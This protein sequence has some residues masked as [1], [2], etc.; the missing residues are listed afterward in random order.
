MARG[1]WAVIVRWSVTAARG[2]VD[3]GDPVRRR[4]RDVGLRVARERDAHGFVE[5]RCIGGRVEVVDGGDHLLEEAALRVAVDHAHGVGDVVGH[6]DLG[7]VR[8]Y[9]D[10]DGVHADVDAVDHLETCRVD[11][12]N[13]VG[14]CVDDVDE[15]AVD[16]DRVGMRTGERRPADVLGDVDDDARIGPEAGGR[17]GAEHNGGPCA[18]APSPLFPLNRHPPDR[19]G[20]VVRR[21]PSVAGELSTRRLG[22]QGD[23]PLRLPGGVAGGVCW[24]H[25]ARYG[26]MRRSRAS[27]TKL[28]V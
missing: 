12:I 25:E 20:R 14:R 22:L 23:R 6:P 27:P 3:D 15:A 8:P 10:G 11:D 5:L 19:L 24:L 1:S 26:G 28:L 21:V 2:G 17:G 13:R 9:G 7:A 4:Q 18:G 16:D